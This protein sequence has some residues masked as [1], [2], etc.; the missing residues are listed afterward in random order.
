MEENEIKEDFN[1]KKHGVH[2]NCGCTHEMDDH[3][4]VIEESYEATEGD[5]FNCSP[6]M[7]L[8]NLP[9]QST[10]FQTIASANSNSRSF[11]ILFNSP[12]YVYQ[13]APSG[14]CM[15]A[16]A[17]REIG[18]GE[19]RRGDDRFLYIFYLL[20][21]RNFI[22]ANRYDG[23]VFQYW[24]QNGQGLLVSRE[25]EPN[26][27]QEFALESINSDTFR[28][29]TG[30][31]FATVCY[32][33]FNNWTKIVSRVDQP[34]A[35]NATLRHRSFLNINLPPLSNLTPLQPLQPLTGLNDAGP[36]SDQAPRGIIG[37][38]YIP[39]LF[40]NDPV[41]TLENRIKQSPYYVLEHRQYWHRLWTD[42]FTAGERRE[43]H[44]VTGITQ[45]AQNDMNNR[46]N[47]TIGADG[48]SRLRFGNLS[49]P[50]SQ[51]ILLN[52]N[53]LGSF[54]NVNHGLRTDISSYLNTQFQQVRFS[55]FVKAYEYRLTRADGSPVGTPWVVLDR[56]EMDLRTYPHNMRLNLEN[57]KIVNSDNSYDL[58]VWK[59]PIQLKD[60]EIITEN[61]KNSKPYYN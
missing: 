47:I 56:K 46:I 14:V 57:D 9:I 50:F 42:V 19:E 23:F 27:Y 39:C 17:S 44:E 55:R 40:V 31:T 10:R 25:Y 21:N 30:N 35:P 24:I 59:T 60:G 54:S 15:T 5:F 2:S 7:F 37:R 53:T 18:N 48:P 29:R 16:N 3:N 36:S 41:L 33:A 4:H 43:Y 61:D 52:S 6:N 34:T 32:G 1:K 22:I 49:A 28:L 45:N 58:S 12:G 13:G 8:L 51:Q 20:D 11:E 38:T 26:I